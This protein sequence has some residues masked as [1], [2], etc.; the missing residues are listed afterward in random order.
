[1]GILEWSESSVKFLEKLDGKSGE[2]I[3]RKMNIL[4]MNL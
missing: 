4:R 2:R 1:M 3:V